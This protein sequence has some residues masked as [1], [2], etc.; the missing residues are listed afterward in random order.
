MCHSSES[1]GQ[2]SRFQISA[3]RPVVHR[4]LQRTTLVRRLETG[5]DAH[6]VGVV[7]GAES[8]RVEDV[9]VAVGAVREDE[10]AVDDAV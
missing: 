2:V 3:D 9:G 10:G 7:E 4:S 8:L 6:V 5:E 1:W